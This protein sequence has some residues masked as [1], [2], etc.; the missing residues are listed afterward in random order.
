M[1][2][3]I[4]STKKHAK[5][6]LTKRTKQYKKKQRIKNKKRYKMQMIKNDKTLAGVHTRVFKNRKNKI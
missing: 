4:S 6:S 2:S 5:K 3:A 1:D